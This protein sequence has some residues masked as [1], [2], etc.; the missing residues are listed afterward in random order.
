MT[1][2]PTPE[3]VTRIG[4]VIQQRLG[5]GT[6]TEH[7]CGRGPDDLASRAAMTWDSRWSTGTGPHTPMPPTHEPAA[8]P[9]QSG[10]PRS[11][12]DSADAAPTTEPPGTPTIAVVPGAARFPASVK[13]GR[14]P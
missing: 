14:H 4:S 9:D 6:A 13:A 2:E 12:F 11:L 7:S 5:L 3:S 10:P 8:R 1:G